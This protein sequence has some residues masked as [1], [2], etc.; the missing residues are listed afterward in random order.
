[1]KRYKFYLTLCLVGVSVSGC[2]KSSPD[3]LAQA[4]FDKGR[5]ADSIRTCES[6][7]EDSRD[8]DSVIN[9]QILKGRCLINLGATAQKIGQDE[10]ATRHLEQAILALTKAIEFRPTPLGLY[11]RSLAHKLLGNVE[12]SHKDDLAAKEIDPDYMSAYT[13]DFRR[14]FVSPET[15]K[16]LHEADS[17]LE[18]HAIDGFANDKGPAENSD[19]PLLDDP[20][21]VDDPTELDAEE[22]DS[23]KLRND[24]ADSAANEA[25]GQ[26][27]RGLPGTKLP[28]KNLP[29]TKLP[30]SNQGESGDGPS[31]EDSSEGKERKKN[32]FVKRNRPVPA[33]NA[34]LSVPRTDENPSSSLPNYA[35]FGSGGPL[36]GNTGSA[37]IHLPTTGVTGNHSR[38]IGVDPNLPTTG[39][40]GPVAAPQPNTPLPG[41]PFTGIPHA[42]AAPF[43]SGTP[44]GTVPFA[45]RPSTGLGRQVSPSPNYNL[46]GPVPDGIGFSG[47]LPYSAR[48]QFGSPAAPITTPYQ[49]PPQ[50]V[51]PYSS[52]PRAPNLNDFYQPQGIT[53]IPVPTTSFNQ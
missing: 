10:K 33:P 23:A 2:G 41:T 34:P 44:A 40:A 11:Q 49:A 5:F 13:N 7:I 8:E 46:R 12:A 14:K 45:P 43:A 32:G 9:A 15:Q 37:P 21:S 25:G 29:G 30:G 27:P 4:Q 22:T 24:S 31:E 6:I 42:P 28:G 35:P 18:E 51:D 50:L 52:V 26:T 53:P 36:I 19:A 39:Y 17:I 3:Q 16:F 1:M 47:A 20:Y 38:I 48:S